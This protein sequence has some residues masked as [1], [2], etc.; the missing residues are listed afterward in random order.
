MIPQFLEKFKAPHPSLS[1]FT[2]YVNL[3]EVKIGRSYFLELILRAKNR[4]SHL[5]N[6]PYIFKT[7]FL[8]FRN[9]ILY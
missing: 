1:T 3:P 4:L 8:K 5:I 6:D 2:C 9:V 7:I